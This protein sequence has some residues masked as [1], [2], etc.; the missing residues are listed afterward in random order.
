MSVRP[1]FDNFLPP[2]QHRVSYVDS[3]TNLILKTCWKW[4]NHIMHWSPCSVLAMSTSGLS[5]CHASIIFNHAST[6]NGKSVRQWCSKNSFKVRKISSKRW[7]G[8]DWT[9]HNSYFVI[10]TR[11]WELRGWMWSWPL[12]VMW[13]GHRWC[14][15]RTQREHRCRREIPRRI[16]YNITGQRRQRR[17]GPTSGIS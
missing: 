15:S 13:A 16:W 7:R 6:K 4:V 12:E 10:H 1:N 9:F 17:T 3:K 5:I 11:R 2:G 14:G 8:I